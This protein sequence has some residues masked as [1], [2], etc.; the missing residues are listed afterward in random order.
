MRPSTDRD[1]SLVWFVLRAYRSERALG[2]GF[3]LWTASGAEDAVDHKFKPED[4]DGGDCYLGDEE[5]D[6]V[7]AKGRAEDSGGECDKG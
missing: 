1:L 2:G 3:Y 7:R 5:L 4:A 6:A